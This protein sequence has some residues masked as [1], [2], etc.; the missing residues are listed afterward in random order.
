VTRVFLGALLL[1][2]ATLASAA[3][4]RSVMVV[5]VTDGG[6]ITV[7]DGKQ[8]YKI[9]LAGINTPEKGQ[10]FAKR[11]H[12]NLSNV[13]HEKQAIVD[14]YKTDQYKLKV[15]RV[16]VGGNDIALAQVQAGLAWHYKRFEN[17]QTA[18]GRVAYAQAEDEAR[19]RK[20]GLWQDKEP[21]PPWEFRRKR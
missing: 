11:A 5:G 20:R 19:M 18:R 10:P 4:L 2:A 13:A 6:T 15:C 17:E 9:R 16:W 1:V 8:N 7:R 3:E 21:V 14:C 12:Q